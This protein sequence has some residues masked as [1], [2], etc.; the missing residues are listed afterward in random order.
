MKINEKKYQNVYAFI[1]SVYVLGIFFSNAILSISTIIIFSM[2]ILKYYSTNEKN[3]FSVFQKSMLCIFFIY[4][5][6]SIYASATT[7]ESL[8]IV[9][10]KL[11]LF[12]IA[13]FYKSLFIDKK[14][15]KTIINFIIIITIYISI[16]TIFIYFYDV[17][18]WKDAYTKGKILP[19]YIHHGKFSFII[20]CLII[21]LLFTLKNNKIKIIL[22]IYFI[23]YLHFL[24]AKTGLVL[25]YLFAFFFILYQVANKKWYYLLA[26]AVPYLLYSISPTLQ[27]KKSYIQYD[28]MQYNKNKNIEY[29]DAQRLISYRI[30]LDIFKENKILGVGLANYKKTTE[31]KYV[32]KYGYLDNK[33]MMYV[34]NSYLHIAASCGIVGLIL[35]LLSILGILYHYGKKSNFLPLLLLV[36]YFIVCSWDAY[37]EQLAGISI[38]IL[39]NILGNKQKD[40]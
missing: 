17:E 9:V 27:L 34:H 38:F 16:Y 8:R 25:L 40:E 21:Y 29:A 12:G 4:L 22:I 36:F 33:K 26:F 5:F 35:Y 13:L 28:I 30:A 1:L 7:Q 10:S 6:W 32:E 23:L 31:K 2:A 18:F 15:S 14:K 3:H 19:T 24:S 11:S 39:L 20:V 37:T